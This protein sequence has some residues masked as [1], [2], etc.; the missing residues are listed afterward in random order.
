[1]ERC[2][3]IRFY[4]GVLEEEIQINVNTPNEVICDADTIL[5]DILEDRGRN[6]IEETE[7]AEDVFIV[8]EKAKDKKAIA[9]MFEVLCDSSFQKHL[10]KYI[11]GISRNH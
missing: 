1:M 5:A 4:N 11:Q 3:G 10:E 6:A 7:I 8:W 2:R 9:D